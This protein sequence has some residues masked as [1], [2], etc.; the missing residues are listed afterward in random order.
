MI[1][2]L[3]TVWTVGRHEIADSIR[4]RRVI[5]LALLYLA[6]SAAGTAFFITLLQRIEH[7]LAAS[8]GL[9]VANNTGSVTATLWKSDA[10]R[11]ILVSLVGDRKLAES[12]LQ[13]PPLA[14][15][16]GWL[17]FTFA[18]ALVML[19]S[20]SRISEELWSG[21]V[22]FVLFRAPRLP[23]CLGK[24]AGQAVQLLLALVLSAAAAWLV[25]LLRMH[26]FDPG[27]TAWAM[28]DFSARAW[29]YSLA[30]LGLALGISQVCAVPNLALAFGFMA[31]IGMAVLSMVSEHL[32]GEHWRRAWDLVN[33]LTPGGHRMDLWWGDLAHGLPAVVFLLTLGGAYLLAGYAVFSRR[34]L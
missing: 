2:A 10:F 22:R 17:S 28:L 25:G 1:A 6:G 34:N 8:L 3:R 15:Y 14:L 26:A 23:W 33:V 24:F 27:A 20:S 9:A 13:T 5:V 7:Q 30:F 12:L 16:Y 29:V 11:S 21:S 4:S 31:M 32:A 18:P 19:M